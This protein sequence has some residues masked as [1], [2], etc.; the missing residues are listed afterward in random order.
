M[1]AKTLINLVKST[2][3]I[4]FFKKIFS[5][6]S[7]FTIAIGSTLGIS[8]TAN[9][10]NGD[11]L[12]I[13]TGQDIAK[14]TA[15]GNSNNVITTGDFD[16]II[17]AENDL[18]SDVAIGID[19]ITAE[20]DSTADIFNVLFDGVA[21]T[22]DE[23]V[24]SR[25]DNLT[26]NI[27]DATLVS[28]LI[29]SGAATGTGANKLNINTL[30]NATL[31]LNGT[32]T[33]SANID[34]AGTLKVAGTITLDEAIGG[35][36]DLGILDVDGSL[37]TTAATKGDILDLDGTIAAATTVEFDN[38]SN[39]NGT[40]TTSGAVTL[41]GASVLGGNST[42]TTSDDIVKFGS[43]VNGAG[44]NLTIDSGTAATNFD[45]IVGGASGQGVGAIALT[46]ALDL[47]AAITDAESISVS[48]ASNLGANITT[49]GTT[50]T[51][52]T[53]TDA[54][55]LSAATTL[56][57][58]NTDI[59]LEEI[60]GGSV[61]LTLVAGTGN[62]TTTAAVASVADLTIT[63]AATTSFEAAVGNANTVINN[64]GSNTFDLTL[65][66]TATVDINAG[67]T[68]FS[69]AVTS[70][71]MNVAGAS[72]IVNI[73]AAPNLENLTIGAGVVN[74]SVKDVDIDD[75]DLNAGD[76]VVEKT[77]V[78]GDTIFVSNTQTGAGLAGTGEIYMPVNLSNGQTLVLFQDSN[79]TTIANTTE[80]QV[81]AV[82]VDTA[83]TD[84][85]VSEVG[86]N[87]VLTSTDKSESVTGSELGI[88]GNAAKGLLA[89]RNSAIND[90]TAD[91]TAEDAFYSVLNSKSGFS[92]SDVTSLAKQVAPQ[93]DM[94]SGSSV[95][96][97]AV[98]GSIQGI[99]SNRM[100]SLRSGDA[101]FGTG[102]AAG[103]MSAQSGFIQVFGSEATQKSKKVGSGTQDGF[104][105]DTQ[106]VAIGFDGVTDEGLTIGVSV[107]TANTDV[108][109]KGLGK[110]KNS[111]DTYSAS[112][113]MD[114][115][116]DN[117]YVE[118]SLTF[119]VNENTTS[120]KL[121]S[122]GLNRTYTGSYDSQ[123]LSFNLT[124]GMPNEVASGYYLTPFGSFTATSMDVDAYTEKST[125]AND[126]L[127]LKVAQDDIN[128][129]I[130]TVGFKYHAEMDN[131]GTPMISIAINN[132][133]GDSTIDSTNTF[134]G[135][136][137]AF[138]T[139]T[140]V[141]E[142]SA[143]LGLGYSYG[144]DAASIEIAY[145]ADA[146]D[147]DYMSHYGSIKIVGKF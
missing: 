122:A 100:A 128:S 13:G 138:K 20:D 42:I 118:G 133:F 7:I 71:T 39:L 51:T 1:S 75:L 57:T 65:A 86:N 54:A 74:L 26:I 11:G 23:T 132:E 80:A 84:Y 18:T 24:T 21:L 98:T 16:L 82:V 99:M 108:D 142:L 45:G 97:Q 68:T 79:N 129:M 135:G 88:T 89:A 121:T 92:T 62:I 109:G 3:L 95:A 41:T 146:N 37:T 93:T 112:L 36:T 10:N 141:E 5:H 130:G 6:F 12:D 59:S 72:S 125:V 78:N 114:N 43:T 15:D 52:I 110:S 8:N 120:R 87:V 101:Y 145:E 55:T 9:A 32:V 14:T 134:Q 2:G 27:G 44:I 143:T 56:T 81:E 144:T 73:D 136:G 58:A 50:G 29:L 137:T 85:V 25:D 115:A 111:I 48:L 22:V 4:N 124:A 19:T 107:A 40:M 140:A 76:I 139:S 126:S 33:H 127:R 94:I 30:G 117:G 64:S 66:S 90:T 46:G 35:N 69:G 96:A 70:P 53:L 28:E 67:T 102:V 47:D 123:S 60:V 49:T 34:G 103:G 116:T 113:Y 104:D 119:G 61:N 83:L 77:V 105:S 147:D 106:G 91:G 38:T 63:S 131:G 31:T 17:D